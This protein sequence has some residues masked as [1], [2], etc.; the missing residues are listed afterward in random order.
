MGR[1]ADFES[2]LRRKSRPRFGK[3][4]QVDLHNHT[5]KSFDY[6]YSGSDIVD[7]L[8]KRILDKD[9][10]IIMFT[11]HEELPDESFVRQLSEKTGRVIL[12]G[13][14]LNVFVDAWDKPEAKIAKNLYYHLL[15]GFDPNGRFSPDYWLNDIYRQCGEETRESGGRKLRGITASVEQLSRVVEEANAIIIP[16]HLH[17]VDD[18]TVS[19]SID[20][21]YKD[22]EFL[23]D[24]RYFSA[25]EVKSPKTAAFF[26]G[27][28][29]ET[30]HLYISCIRSSDSHEPDN[31]GWRSCYVQMEVPSYA[32]LKA[33]LDLPFRI[34]L[35]PP[36]EPNSYVV[37]LHVHGQFFPDL[38]LALSPHCN[39]LIGVKGSGKSSV[40]EALRFVL[41]A[42]VPTSR[43]DTVRSHLNAI[44]GPG[45]KVTALVK[46]ADGARLLVERAVADGQFL[47][48][49]ETDRQERFSSAD[50]LRFPAYLLGWHEI[51][52]VAT[53]ANIRLQYMDS[54]A[55]RGA[56]RALEEEARAIG[57]KVREKHA[58]A[59]D[60][61]NAY[62]QLHDRVSRLEELRR[63]LKE[64]EDAN[65]IVLRDKYQ[66]ATDQ[67]ETLARALEELRRVR[68]KVI[69]HVENL[70]MDVTI[71]P[72]ESDSILGQPVVDARNALQELF[73][74]VDAS[75]T[76]LGT[77]VDLCIQRL[78][79]KVTEVGTAFQAFAEY[80][81]GELKN[82]NPE[83]QRLLE[84]HREVLEQTKGL[85]V[86]QRQR[87][88][89]KQEVQELLQEL[90]GLCDR[91]ASTL[92]R[93]S[94]LREGRVKDLS[95]E[96][97]KYDV[98]LKVVRQ[99]DSLEF[100]NLARQF[101]AGA[102]AL[103]ELRAKLPERLAH[104][105]LRKAYGGLYGDLSP[106]Y[107]ALLFATAEIGYFLNIFEEDD[108]EVEL[109]VGKP[110]QEFTPISQLSAGQRCTVIFPILL[111]LEEGPLVIDQPEDNLDNRHIADTIALA[112]LHGKRTRQMLFTSH[113]ANLVVLSD[114]ELIAA[115]ESDGSQGR[116]EEK[117]F[118]A[119]HESKITEHVL[120]ILDGGQRALQLR[121]LKYGLARKEGLAK[122]WQIS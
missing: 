28:H 98:R 103:S 100:Q 96:L 44:L 52:Q 106:E 3:W 97:E 33:A 91:A 21:I 107:G 86:L 67:R 93:R 111:R 115:F 58:L 50:G 29:S 71:G 46:R 83:Q 14:E 118:L 42:D 45:G 43:V 99:K 116:I 51:E 57:T 36:S 32:E 23:A 6:Q 31:L 104:L 20:D 92:D 34:S 7:R 1:V 9:L 17:T 39:F 55:G 59:A 26:D 40:F 76:D 72:L 109:R 102:K 5:P 24:A 8:A 66:I 68:E 70:L 61:Y 78:D 119:T 84:S 117:G 49:F 63:G 10:S 35:E 108:L 87:D 47:V 94:S 41:G 95:Q 122:H 2:E 88:E 105:C 54:I 112:L 27:Q 16:A 121:A 120:S 30:G 4:H 110:G 90:M 13:V 101:G 11:D 37:G 113:N 82:L 75:G 77:K 48:T 56:V 79:E 22:S 80:Y 85:A 81:A 65:L 12:R 60:R 38:W 15:V 89:T 19:R 69:G 74:R 114:A 25:L 18:S 53:D 73:S 62:R 64:L